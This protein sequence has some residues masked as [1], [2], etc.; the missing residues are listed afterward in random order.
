MRN[1]S[2]LG[3]RVVVVIMNRVVSPKESIADEPVL[4]TSVFDEWDIA[5]S[6]EVAEVVIDRDDEPAIIN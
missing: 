3:I 6:I 5:Q 2:N 1:K 4:G